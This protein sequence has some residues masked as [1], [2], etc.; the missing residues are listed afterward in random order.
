MGPCVGVWVLGGVRVGRRG[1]AARAGGTDMIEIP[2]SHLLGREGAVLDAGSRCGRGRAERF[3]EGLRLFAHRLSDAP[4]CWDC[5]VSGEGRQKT[6]TPDTE[7]LAT[8]YQVI[9]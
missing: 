9:S 3:L 4:S 2:L 1:A 8:R 7:G 5:A 6:S